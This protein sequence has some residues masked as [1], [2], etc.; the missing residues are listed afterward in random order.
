[1]LLKR[2]LPLFIM[3]FL[4]QSCKK[5]TEDFESDF[6]LYQDYISG[7]TSGLVSS[8][9]DIRLVFNFDKSDWIAGQEITEELFTI[10]PS[11]KGK[12]VALSTNTLSF[13]PENK[14]KQDTE[15]SEE[16][17]VG[18]ECRTRRSANH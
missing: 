17:R 7:F 4:V 8:E 6:L 3:L 16:R 1:M 2:L 15:R 10:S 13:V 18:K 5:S 14:L 9:T 11:I 12:I